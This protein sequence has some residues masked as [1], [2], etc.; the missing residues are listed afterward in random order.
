MSVQTVRWCVGT[1]APPAYFGSPPSLDHEAL[2]EDFR[3]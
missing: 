3:P 1:A 2:I